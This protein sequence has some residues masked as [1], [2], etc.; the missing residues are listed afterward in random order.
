MT[1]IENNQALSPEDMLFLDAPDAFLKW[2][3]SE[4][5]D[6]DA[7][8]NDSTTPLA[9]LAI[10]RRHTLGLALLLEHGAE[11]KQHLKMLKEKNLEALTLLLLVQIG[12]LELFKDL[13]TAGIDPNISLT[14]GPIPIPNFLLRRVDEKQLTTPILHLLIESPATEFCSVLLDNGALVDSV[15]SEGN[16]AL[17]VA[18]TKPIITEDGTCPNVELLLAHKA[19]KDIKNRQGY[20]PVEYLSVFFMAVNPAL[21]EH[22]AIQN[23]KKRITPEGS[24]SSIILIS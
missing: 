11:L 18:A 10:E 3:L 15:D 1:A 8:G 20:T 22:P 13:L 7:F 2:I 19:T 9:L 21:I 23:L 16:T 24:G 4:E 17:H 5:G 6:A 14:L 12:H